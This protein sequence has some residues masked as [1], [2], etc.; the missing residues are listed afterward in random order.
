MLERGIDRFWHLGP[1]RSNLT[2]VK[3]LARRAQVA[4][5]DEASDLDGLL[6]ALDASDSPSQAEE[7]P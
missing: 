1:G 6:R 5:F 3:R 2:H 7:K 4:S